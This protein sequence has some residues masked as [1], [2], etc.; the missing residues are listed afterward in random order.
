[1]SPQE[2]VQLVDWT[3]LSDALDPLKRGSFLKKKRQGAV[4]ELWPWKPW[5]TLL[6]QPLLVGLLFGCENA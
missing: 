5:D 2:I 6:T 4:N 3:Y 1:M